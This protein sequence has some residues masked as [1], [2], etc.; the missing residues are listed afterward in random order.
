LSIVSLWTLERMFF[1]RAWPTYSPYMAIVV[2]TP[3]VAIQM[4]LAR[5]K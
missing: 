1:E 2:A 3:I 4:V 5:R